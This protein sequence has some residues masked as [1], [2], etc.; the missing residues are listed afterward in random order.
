MRDIDRSG[1]RFGPIWLQPDINYIHLA[2]L[3]YASLVTIGM[4]TFVNIG[5]PYVLSV[6][7]GVPSG[8]M[9]RIVGFLTVIGEL[10]IM[11]TVGFYGVLCDR[12]G[13]R[14]VYAFGMI[15]MG[16]SYV[17]YPM[18]TAVW[19]LF[20]YRAIYATGVSAATGMLGIVTNDYPQEISRGKLIALTGMLLGIGAVIANG[21]LRSLPPAFVDDGLDAITAGRYTHWI[22]AAVC[23][24]S[25][26]VVGIGLK[27]GTP[28][29]ERPSLRDLILSGFTEARKPRTGLAYA[30]AFVARSDL[31]IIGTF[32]ILWGM[33]AGTAM[34]LSTPDSVKRGVALFIVAQASGLIWAPFMGLIVDR[35]NRVSAVAFGCF[36]SFVA[37]MCML[38]V[39]DPFDNAYLPF[40]ALLG[41]GQVSIFYSSQALIGQEAPADR[42]GSVMGAFATCGAIGILLFSG[43]GGII[44]DSWRP[45]GVFVFVGCA[46]ALIGIVAILVFWVAFN[47][48]YLVPQLPQQSHQLFVFTVQHFAG[49]QRQ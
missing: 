4:L 41:V 39:A 43:I 29:A 40:F 38:F 30:T 46:A 14:P 12:I 24:F 2:A 5:Q 31:V 13:R 49:N 11:A 16:L 48:R 23:L 18:A 47:L 8:E 9:G 45:A 3:L 25:A 27:P 28:K 19:H 22:V 1:R 44:F 42:R 33:V 10:T 36:V 32:T 21:I 26:L 17:L 7:L 34:G 15:F 35:F 20:V 6:N 37:F